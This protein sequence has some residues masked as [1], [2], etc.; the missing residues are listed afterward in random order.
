MHKPAH[1]G[2][3]DAQELL[4]EH[5]AEM[6]AVAEQ[7][8]QQH[9]RAH[10]WDLK[11]NDVAARRVLPGVDGQVVVQG[12]VGGH[13]YDR[14]ANGVTVLCLHLHSPHATTSI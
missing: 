3:R 4:P 5:A 12:R 6:R 10:L 2:A 1:T 9:Q 8:V 7:R 13:Y 14:G 11:A